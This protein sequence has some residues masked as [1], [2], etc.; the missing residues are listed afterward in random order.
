MGIMQNFVLLLGR[1]AISAIFLMSGAG[2][3]L[4]F[5]STQEH[6]KGV[7]LTQA[8]GVLLAGAIV[9]E[10]VGGIS[11]V[12]GLKARFGAFLLLVFIV[13]A[14]YYFH[15]FWTLP[16]TDPNYRNQM[17]HFLKNVSI[18]GGLLMVMGF[19]PGRLSIDGLRRVPITNR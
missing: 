16:S 3:I 2:K 19:G 18:M 17:I 15:D 9:L 4:D 5:A 12:L 1:I 13:L 14:S 6:M 10:L 11:L 8:T 7:G